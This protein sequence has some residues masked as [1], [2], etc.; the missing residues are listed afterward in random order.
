MTRLSIMVVAAACSSA[1]K[2]TPKPAIDR[3]SP[4]ALGL[5]DAKP[6]KPWQVPP[7]CTARPVE[8]TVHVKTYEEDKTRFQCEEGIM[9]GVGFGRGESLVMTTRELSPATVGYDALD[10]G[11][12]ITFVGRQR[13]PCPDDPK[14]MPVEQTFY[15]LAT[16]AGDRAFAETHCTIETPC[17]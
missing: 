4:A 12:T 13:S 11:K 2:E 10:D 14:P 5:P 9:L 3:C 15:F 16:T 17:K 7:K 1:T 6:L 8:G